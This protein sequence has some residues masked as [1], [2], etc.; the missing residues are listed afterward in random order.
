MLK[1]KDEKQKTLKVCLWGNSYGGV[2]Y[3]QDDE[4]LIRDIDR[5][6]E[7]WTM[8]PSEHAEAI[9]VLRCVP[10]PDHAGRFGHTDN[11]VAP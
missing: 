2:I 10:S 5:K 8:L 3:P 6:A 11:C 1:A 9:Q 4:E 7:K